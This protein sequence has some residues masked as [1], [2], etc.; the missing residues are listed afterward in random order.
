VYSTLVVRQGFLLFDLFYFLVGSNIQKTISSFVGIIFY[1]IQKTL[2]SFVGIIFYVMF[3][4][5]SYIYFL[6]TALSSVLG[7]ELGGRF[8][9]LSNGSNAYLHDI[10]SLKTTLSSVLGSWGVDPQT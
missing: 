2:L 5:I 9:D 6:K 7:S 8:S 4:E 3:Q 10:N 1:Y